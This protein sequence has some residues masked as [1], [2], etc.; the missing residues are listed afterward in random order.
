MQ[1]LGASGVTA[2]GHVVEANARVH[3]MPRAQ[4]EVEKAAQDPSRFRISELG[5][6]DARLHYLL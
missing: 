3:V 6:G 1:A 4:S 5:V 2:A